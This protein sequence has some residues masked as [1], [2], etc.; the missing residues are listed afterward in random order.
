MERK[1]KMNGIPFTTNNVL[2]FAMTGLISYGLG[3]IQS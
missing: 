3:Q 1:A 2:E